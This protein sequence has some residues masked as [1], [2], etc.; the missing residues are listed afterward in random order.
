[1]MLILSGLIFSMLRSIS[2]EPVFILAAALDYPGT[3][4]ATIQELILLWGLMTKD[5]ILPLPL[6]V[7]VMQT[8]NE[9]QERWRDK[10]SV[11]QVRNSVVG[12]D[13]GHCDFDGVGIRVRTLEDN[14]WPWLHSKVNG[15]S[16]YCSG[17]SNR[18]INDHSRFNG[19]ASDNMVC[20]YFSQCI[21]IFGFAK[22]LKGLRRKGCKGS[23]C[24]GK[25]S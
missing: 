21:S 25:K 3:V 14:S 6:V 7:F 22:K 24:R 10:Y 4:S 23:I 1:M 15:L 9:R 2:D 12:Q 20:K 19:D 11:D 8:V 13:V 17:R 18:P 5:T 16:L